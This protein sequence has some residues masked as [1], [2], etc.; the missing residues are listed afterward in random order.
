MCWKKP[1]FYWKTNHKT[2]H[3]RYTNRIHHTFL[4]EKEKNSIH[5]S[6]LHPIFCW[7]QQFHPLPQSFVVNDSPK[8]VCYI[9][10]AYVSH[11]WLVV[12]TP[13]KNISQLGWLFPIYGKIKNVPKHQPDTHYVPLI[14]HYIEPSVY[15]HEKGALNPNPIPLVLQTTP[16]M[17][18]I[19]HATSQSTPRYTHMEYPQF[20]SISRWDCP[21]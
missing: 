16:F 14:F 6:W 18:D 17:L 2:T 21:W 10:L 3:S 11:Y 5:E 9:L 20:S 7:L 15:V 13:L 12:W 1:V 4:G 8:K 19:S